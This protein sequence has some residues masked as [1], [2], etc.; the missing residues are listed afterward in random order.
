MIFGAEAIVLQYSAA[1]LVDELIRARGIANFC[2]TF[3]AVCLLRAAGDVGPSVS[4]EETRRLFDDLA[5]DLN[6]FAKRF[7]SLEESGVQES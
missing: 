3:G 5:K 6:A 4:K 2:D 7:R 1:E